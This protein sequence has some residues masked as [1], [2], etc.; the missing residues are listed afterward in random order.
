MLNHLTTYLFHY[1][2]V[3]IPHVGTIQIVQRPPQLDVVDKR[4]QPP[5]YLV[6]FK[7]EEDVTDHQIRFLNNI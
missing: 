2:K 3:S 7:K 1:K 5:F 6:E 4:L